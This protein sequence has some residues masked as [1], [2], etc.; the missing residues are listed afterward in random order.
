MLAGGEGVGASGNYWMPTVM[1]DVPSTARI[2]SDKPFGPV[3]AIQPITD[4]EDAITEAN[5]LPYGLAGYGFTRS[6]KTAHIPAQRVAVGMLW[7]NPGSA[8]HPELPFV[9]IGASG[10]GLEGGPRRLKPIS[11]SGSPLPSR[12]GHAAR[13]KKQT[14]SPAGRGREG[15][16]FANAS[17]A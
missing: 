10:Y 11:T 15:F 16:G 7:L 14:P 5:R 4:L 8:T 9:G 12:P 6:L 2:F 3:A 1:T 13:Q 17:Y